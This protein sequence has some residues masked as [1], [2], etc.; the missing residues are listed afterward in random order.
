[1][2]FLYRPTIKEFGPVYDVRDYG[3]TG[4]GTTI[5]NTAIAAAITA[6][7]STG[8]TV[9]FPRGTY[10]L[11][12]HISLSNVSNV[13]LVGESATILQGTIVKSAFQIT[14][15]SQNIT[16]SGL[17]ITGAQQ[18][19]Q[20]AVGDGAG[21][22]IGSYTAG[23]GGT[24]K[25]NITIENC[26]I[27]G[28][29]HA[30]VMVYGQQSGATVPTNQQIFIRN[31]HISQ[32]QNGVFLYKN[33]RD[34]VI[35]GNTIEG[36]WYDGIICDTKTSTD[37]EV[38]QPNYG[39]A[40]V[41]N[42]LRNIGTYGSVIGILVKGENKSITIAGNTLYDIGVNQ[43]Q[44]SVN[45][46]AIQVLQEA[47]ANPGHNVTISGNTIYNVQSLTTAFG[48]Y[49]GDLSNVAVTGNTIS[50]IK[51][52]ALYV[53][54]TKNATV[55]GNT[56]L[57]PGSTAITVNGV[58]GTPAFN[59]T[60][61]GNAV[62]KDTGA[63]TIGVIMDYADN[64]TLMGNAI[65]TDFTTRLSKSNNTTNLT[66]IANGTGDFSPPK[67]LTD[68]ATITVDA[69][70]GNHFRVTLGGNRTLAA[71]TNPTE[72]QRIVFEIIQ[73]AT[74]SRTLTW[75]GSYAFGTDVPS[76]T[77]TATANKRD[78]VTFV[79]NSTTAKWYCVEAVKGY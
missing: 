61:A 52:Y 70:T 46:Y 55:T 49:V 22:L 56:I 33:A 79:Y 73:D 19:A 26:K 71:P 60:V 65:T 57:R 13:S 17:T 34:V 62:Y 25:Q 63:A 43:Q 28:F 59:T 7:A 24:T 67:T 53:Y 2:K 9:R 66:S 77:L 64:T 41:G 76:P 15:G 8:G 6:A 39:V 37:T 30:G 69:G 38:A 29:T 36:T 50:D 23:D 40:I 44:A 16:I 35:Q 31:N 68:A 3:A 14:N 20:G 21:I 75:N 11:N 51:N 4:D 32:C 47:S 78:F 48:I 10:K 72:G 58:S 5:D 74:G 18:A 42:T 12:T 1:M 27:S 45:V 54:K